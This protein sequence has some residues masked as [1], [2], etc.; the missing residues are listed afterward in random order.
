MRAPD[1]DADSSAYVVYTVGHSNRTLRDFL[2]LIT[3]HEIRAVVDIRRWPSSRKFPHFNGTVLAQSLADCGIRYIHMEPLGGYRTPRADSIN[4][5][6]HSNGFRGY[7]DHMQTEL[8]QDTLRQLENLARSVPTT[9]MC[10][11]ALPWRCHRWLLADLL[12]LRGL[13]VVHLIQPGHTMEH[14]CTPGAVLQAGVV[15]YPRSVE[16]SDTGE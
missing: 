6:L 5:G 7:A 8:F 15:I 11:E 2:Q 14:R 1:V 10:A 9:V 4:I 12:T 3:S 16:G 13:T